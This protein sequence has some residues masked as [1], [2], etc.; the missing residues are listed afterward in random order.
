[1]RVRV[2]ARTRPD[3]GVC[4]SVRQV[5]AASSVAFPPSG[6]PRDGGGLGALARRQW[7]RRRLWVARSVSLLVR[8]RGGGSAA[9]KGL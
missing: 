8:C 6:Q 9:L 5:R 4:L 3:P 7:R 2:R 1:M